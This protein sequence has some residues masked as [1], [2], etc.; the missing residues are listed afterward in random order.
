[1]ISIET[2]RPDDIL[3]EYDLFEVLKVKKIITIL[4]LNY[5]LF[6]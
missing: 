4:G 5:H 2:I 1:M 6:K 3:P